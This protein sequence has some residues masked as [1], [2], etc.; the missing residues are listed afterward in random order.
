MGVILSILLIVV[1]VLLI[2][3]LVGGTKTSITYQV[4]PQDSDALPALPQRAPAEVKAIFDGMPSKWV[5]Y[6]GATPPLRLHVRGMNYEGLRRVTRKLID[7]GVG[8]HIVDRIPEGQLPQFM[9]GLQPQLVA[10]AYVLDWD[11]AQYPNGGAMPF[12]VANVAARLSADPYLMTFV[13][14]E[15]HQL[16]PSWDPTDPFKT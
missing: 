5:T 15:A 3:R 10:E 7:E 9:A 12:S 4:G 1:L 14:D 8:Q 11:G 13:T 6:A 16:S 2:V